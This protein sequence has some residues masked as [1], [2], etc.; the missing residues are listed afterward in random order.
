MK[1]FFTRSSLFLSSLFFLCYHSFSQCGTAP[2]TGTITI[3][4]GTNIVNS[5]YPGTANAASGTTTLTVGTRD[6]RGN[7]TALSNGDMIFIIQMQGADI[8]TSNNDSYGDGVAGGN[9]SGYLSSNLVAGQYEYNIVTGF[10]SGTITVQYPLAN[11]YYARTFSAATGTQ[12]FQ[13]VRVRRYYNL[14]IDAGRSITAP[15]WNGSTGG[16]IVLEAANQITLNGTIDAS[17]LGFRGGG[18]KYFDGADLGN[19][20]GSG[21]ITNN[22]L[23]WNSAVTTAA[24]QTGGAKGEG[25]AGTPI[26]YRAN[27][28]TVTTTNGTLE[29]YIGGAMGR[30]A[31]GNAGGG[32][33][34]G[35]PG[36]NQYNPGGGG[37]GNGGAG[38][39]GGSGWDGGSA[40]PN[41][42]NTGG[43]GGAAFAE[44]SLQRLVLGGGGGAGTSNNS[45]L[46]NGQ[47]LY[48]HLS[49]GASGGGIVIIRAKSYSGSGSVLANGAAATDIQQSGVTDAAGGGGAG[50]TIIVVTNEAGGTIAGTISAQANGGKGGNMETWFAHGPGGGGGGGFVVSNVIA[51]ASIFVN[52]GANGLTRTGSQ[53]GTLNNVYNAASGSVGKKTIL[54]G[55]VGFFGPSVNGSHC[56][57][58]PVT[59]YSWKGVFNNDKTYLNWQTDA[60]FNFSHYVVER[61]TDGRHFSS[62]GQ[63]MASVSNALVQQY[64]YTDAQPASGINYYRLKMVDKD[65]QFTYSAIITIR[66]NVKA[67][68][69]TVSPNP[70]TDHVVIALQSNSEEPVQFRLYNSDGT[71]VWRKTGFVTAGNNAQYYND[72]QFL[73]KGVYILKV[74][75]KETVAEYKLIKQ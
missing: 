18:G 11:S 6:A 17:G 63:V 42:Y 50:G 16:V 53:N 8:N 47:N 28:A 52:G 72:L 4:T 43:F 34:D 13:V 69:I 5:Y 37:G 23:R 45:L 55:P 66:T 9:A 3:G 48:E 10:N 12:S 15:A 2:T 40:N 65:G 74:N 7:A 31:P 54:T 46:N 35:D 29:G 25:I 30:A 59:L 58:L 39:K 32:G 67:F 57:V 70:F 21:T 14:T 20:N 38:G 68:E 51:N 61:S 60:G 1:L 22:D 19:T 33:T 56:G 26:Y 71:L 73:P 75:K 27:G 44:A 49:S 64:A 24:N 62:L 41:T 36:S